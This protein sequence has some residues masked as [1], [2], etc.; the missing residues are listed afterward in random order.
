MLASVAV[1]TRW[2]SFALLALLG[3]N[4]QSS[5]PVA[6]PKK[7]VVRLKVVEVDVSKLKALGFDWSRI[8][9]DGRQES[10]DIQAALSRPHAPELVGFLTAL[11]QNS[12]ARK[13]TEPT[14]ITLDGRPASLAVGNT[15]IDVVPIVRGDGRVM[16]EYRLEIA[17]APPT[18]GTRQISSAPLLRLDAA[19]DVALGKMVTLG[20]G[21][22][23]KITN[24]KTTETQLIVL[25]QVDAVDSNSAV[26]A[27]AMDTAASREITR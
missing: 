9:V 13:L 1:R 6:A 20:H 4:A 17:A 12:L 16:L 18:A 19:T 8:T 10:V 7:L 22:T 26:L 21:R 24:G 11:E 5:E 15:Q 2:L 3:A 25:A 14:L 23:T 27:E